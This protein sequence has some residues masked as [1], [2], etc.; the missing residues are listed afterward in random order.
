MFRQVKRLKVGDRVVLNAGAMIPRERTIKRK[1]PSE[2][3]ADH[4]GLTFEDGSGILLHEKD[5]VEILVNEPFT[6]GSEVTSGKLKL[7]KKQKGKDRVR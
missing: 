7:G 6:A 3:H 2:A 1:A 4:I 5:M